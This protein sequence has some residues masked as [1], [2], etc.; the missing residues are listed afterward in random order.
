MSNDNPVTY[1]KIFTAGAF[2][3]AITGAGISK[4]LGE[5]VIVGLWRGGISGVCAFLTRSIIEGDIVHRHAIPG[6][7]ASFS[8]LAPPFLPGFNP[9]TSLGAGALTVAAIT[10]LANWLVP[11]LDG[12]MKPKKLEYQ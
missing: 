7:A 5:P 10:A 4:V 6:M 9:A 12:S 3:G 1:F 2:F 8:C 11:H